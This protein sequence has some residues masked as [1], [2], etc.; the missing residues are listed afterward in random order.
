MAYYAEEWQNRHDDKLKIIRGIGCKK[1]ILIF[2]IGY[3]PDIILKRSQDLG[4]VH[5]ERDLFIQASG[6]KWT[7]TKEGDTLG[8]VS[9]FKSL[10]N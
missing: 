1:F 5:K 2:Q 7:Q 6:R 8:F 10:E 3:Y 4:R 9:Y